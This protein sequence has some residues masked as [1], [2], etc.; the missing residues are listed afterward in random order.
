MIE[1]ITDLE[2]MRDVSK[3]VRDAGQTIGFVPTM[4]YLHSGHQ[5]L[6][7]QAAAENDFPV[8]S[9]F[10]NPTQFA[11]DEDY[12]TYPRDLARDSALAEAAGCRLIFA[13]P[14]QAIYPLDYS[15]YIEVTGVSAL[16]CGKSRPTH[17]RGVTTIVAK[18]L[19]IVSPDRAY[20]GQKDAQQA[21]IIQKMVRE[22][23]MDVQIV[24]L[25]IVREADGLAMSSRNT[26]L[27]P[28]QRKAARVLHRALLQGRELF[29]GGL[30]KPDELKRAMVELIQ[31]EPLARIDY[32]ELVEPE[33]FTPARS[34]T[35]PML[36][37]LAVYV[38]Q[39]R[40][41]DNLLF[42]IGE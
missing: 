28:E 29:R 4:G 2:A 37:L 34:G 39:T 30:V 8:L 31:A 22:L 16:Y 23:N 40:L 7:L 36:A 9:I 24:V 11:P 20:F 32:V 42:S 12:E 27:S 38:G 17:F 15:T 18:L 26:Y 33:T 13:P 5:S 19:N 3:R 6:I 25:P 35:D 1:V 14:P 21:F 41:I 10:V